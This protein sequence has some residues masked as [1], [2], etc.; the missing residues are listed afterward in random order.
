VISFLKA[1]NRQPAIRFDPFALNRNFVFL[2]K[3]FKF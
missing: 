3:Q 1:N 2:L